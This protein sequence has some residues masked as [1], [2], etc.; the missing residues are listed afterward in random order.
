MAEPLRVPTPAPGDPLGWL[1]ELEGVP[2]GMTA[3]RDGIDAM[4]RD[5]GLRKTKPEQT[6]ESL[7]R[8]AHASAVLEASTSTLEFEL[9]PGG[10]VGLGV[11]DLVQVNGDLVLDGTLQVTDLGG[12]GGPG[13]VY[14]LFNYTG[15]LTNNGLLIGNL[16][17]AYLDFSIPGQVNLVFPIPE[18]TTA[19]LMG[20]SLVMFGRRLRRNRV[21]V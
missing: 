4:L 21:Q 7:L 14:R 16:G 2:S 19:W 9:G 11:N 17:Q 8:G 5:R 3:A 18:P 12:F 10:I 6:T 1:N 15:S 20:V 13:D